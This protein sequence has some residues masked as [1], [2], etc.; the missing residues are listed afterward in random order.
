MWKII[1]SAGGVGSYNLSKT[2]YI[3][4]R[5]N[6]TVLLPC[7]LPE[8][9]TWE[10]IWETNDE[11]LFPN[12]EYQQLNPNGSLTVRV[13]MEDS[14]IF[15]RCV[16]FSADNSEPMRYVVNERRHN[17]TADSVVECRAENKL[18]YQH[19]KA[20]IK[21]RPG[22]D[23]GSLG[24]NSDAEAKKPTVFTKSASIN[25]TILL[26][27][28]LPDRGEKRERFWTVRQEAVVETP[29]YREVNP[30]GSLTLR[31]RSEDS[32]H[33]YICTAYIPGTLVR[34]TYVY[35]ISLMIAA[36]LLQSVENVTLDW[37][38]IY[39]FPC[40][41]GGT[42]HRTDQMI[43][44]NRVVTET[45]HNVTEDSVVEC[46]VKN[47][48][49][50]QRDKAFI[51]VRPGS[52][53]WAQ[54]FG[55]PTGDYCQPYSVAL[56]SSSTCFHFLDELSKLDSQP[57]LVS[58]SRLSFAEN[59]EQALTKLFRAWDLLLIEKQSL[60]STQTDV[61]SSDSIHSEQHAVSFTAWRCVDWAKRLTC[62]LAYPRCRSLDST[63]SASSRPNKFYEDYPIC[64]ADCLTVT[65]LFCLARLDVSW[66]MSALDPLDFD[67][68]GSQEPDQTGWT[69]LLD[70]PEARSSHLPIGELAKQIHSARSSVIRTC[71]DHPGSSPVDS[72]RHV[73]TRLPLETAHIS[74][75]S[76][77]RRKSNQSYINPSTD[78]INCLVGS[79][80]NY[81]GSA[82][83]PD[84][85][86]WAAFYSQFGQLSDASVLSNTWPGLSALSIH[87]FPRS[88]D[89]E[90]S[91]SAVC[92]NPLG[93][94]SKP[95]CI[96]P[97]SNR[98][99]T[100]AI[101]KSTHWSIILCDN[102]PL[103]STAN[104]TLFDAYSPV[105]I[106]QDQSAEL[107]A[108]KVQVSYF[109]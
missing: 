72:S 58:R 97:V 17:I 20:F 93:L 9:S 77:L 99:R 98:S 30:N 19:D 66:N 26:S 90:A 57:Y 10:R 96:G 5:I 3:E 106:T 52:K 34:Q 80:M 109:L 102:I 40:V 25:Q 86:P 18:G 45:K 50:H 6:H 105:V 2:A 15:Y 59:V 70:V 63:S 78:D 43:F 76:K 54:K 68:Y 64:R 23:R 37:G 42:G 48:L 83:T 13:R 73:C 69:Q 7:G 24:T 1:L 107:N 88:L 47:E 79:G 22:T 87:T 11:D 74:H 108:A 32:D 31:V 8:Y 103:C 46:Y 71:F 62:A 4:G 49:G 61:T 41:F 94:A 89:T 101:K 75:D 65:G 33:L 28:G 12:P 91:S 81:R 104:E 67:K 21:V 27:C 92:R 100:N 53:A 84:C 51:K 29:G 16:L 95:F 38:S 44:N 36:S 39:T 60:A 85:L 55:P 14:S 35:S 82:T 56:N